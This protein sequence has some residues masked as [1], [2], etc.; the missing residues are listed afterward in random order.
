M[1]DRFNTFSLSKDETAGVDLEEADVQ[2]RV[3]E[4]LRSL[5]DKIF[6]DKKANFLGLKNTFL[7][8]WQHKGLCKVGHNLFQFIF[9]RAVYREAILLGKPFF[10]DSQLFAFQPWSEDF[11]E[12]DACF[13][14]SPLWVQVWN[15]P[16]HWLPVEIGKK[17]GMMLGTVLDILILE[18]GERII[19]ILSC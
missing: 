19:D 1:L 18:T 2:T 7:K 13:C 11:S 12:E 6:G 4:G 16:F 3:E 9:L 8:L 10:F 5:I 14:R 15:I 17:I